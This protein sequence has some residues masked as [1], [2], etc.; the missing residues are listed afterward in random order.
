MSVMMEPE[1]LLAEMSR[2]IKSVILEVKLESGSTT[3]L[4]KDV[5]RFKVANK[6]STEL[7]TLNIESKLMLAGK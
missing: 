3:T 4:I 6:G 1:P 2:W 5:R 7:A